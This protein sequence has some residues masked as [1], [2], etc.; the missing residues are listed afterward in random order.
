M[1][2]VY[3][4]KSDKRWKKAIALAL[5]RYGIYSLFLVV[6]N[7]VINIVISI[8]SLWINCY[9]IIQSYIEM[10]C[11]F[12]LKVSWSVEPISLNCNTADD[13]Y[14]TLNLSKASFP[15]QWRI[16]GAST[17]P[18]FL[19]LKFFWMIYYWIP[20][21]PPFKKT[22]WISLS[23]CCDKI[24]YTQSCCSF[25]LMWSIARFVLTWAMG[26]VPHVE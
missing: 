2:K 19:T 10:Q 25:P 3:K 11:K 9:K 12:E 6:I 13:Y 21:P 22:G 24:S 20:P 23:L 4:H 18:F 7:I 1:S 17:P 15:N 8:V 5:G 26:H 16:Q 14:H